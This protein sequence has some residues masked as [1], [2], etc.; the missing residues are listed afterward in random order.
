MLTVIQC[1]P[2]RR[3]ER[4]SLVRE[5]ERQEVSAV[6]VEAMA[7]EPPRQTFL[8]TLR[9]AAP[10]WAVYLQDDAWPAPDFAARLKPLL[11]AAAFN[12]L[13][14]YSDRA[15]VSAAVAKGKPLVR[16]SAGELTMAVG[17]V[18]ATEL[19]DPFATFLPEWERSNPQHRAA[20]DLAL[21]AFCR[22]ERLIVRATAPSIVQHRDTES[23]LGHPCGRR[24]SRSYLAAYGEVPSC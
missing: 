2:Q 13:S 11:D 14:L 12:V 20:F 23:F 17:L 24:R 9:A 5:L 1:V 8:R 10:P 18:V 16:L 3:R 7:N 4:Q 21:G 15:C 22:R 19:V 6:C